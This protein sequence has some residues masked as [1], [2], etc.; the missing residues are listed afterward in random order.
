MSQVVDNVAAKFDSTGKALLEVPN[1]ARVQYFRFY[2]TRM[3]ADTSDL[4]QEVGVTFILD[5]PRISA[6]THQRMFV[7]MPPG[8][9]PPNFIAC[10]AGPIPYGPAKVEVFCIEVSPPPPPEPMP[11]SEPVPSA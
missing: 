9:I 5:V 1:G 4:N 7:L 2:Q 3:P 10:K 6:G 11:A 8:M